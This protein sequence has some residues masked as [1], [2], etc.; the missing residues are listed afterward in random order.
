M[1][2]PWVQLLAR[3]AATLA[4]PKRS[5]TEK[6][7]EAVWASVVNDGVARAL[8]K[9]F[10]RRVR[11]RGTAEELLQNLLAQLSLDH[12]YDPRANGPT[13]FRTWVAACAHH[14]LCAYYEA[15][16]KETE[17]LGERI[18]PPPERMDQLVSARTLEAGVDAATMLSQLPQR[19][20]DVMQR[21]IVGETSRESA[22]A[23]GLTEGHVRQLV[24]RSIRSL[25]KEFGITAMKQLDRSGYES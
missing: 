2:D 1:A 20:R 11:D 10:F 5:W 6:E 12:T 4:K 18:D 21:W 9:G 16:R 14:H 19:Q 7:T 23:L 8:Y 13:A 25:R 24:F 3:R 15:K 17:R 22:A